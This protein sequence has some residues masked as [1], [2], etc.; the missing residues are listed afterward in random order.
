MISVAELLKDPDFVKAVVVERCTG[1][2]MVEGEYKQNDPTKLRIKASVQHPKPAELARFMAE[3]ERNVAIVKV[4]SAEK[5]QVT[6]GEGSQSDV[7]QWCGG[8]YRVFEVAP[9]A[10]NGHW[11]AFA[12]K[13]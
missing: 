1:S 4:Y 2:Y 5:L 10:D 9:W 8:R 11:V 13:T 6:G 3:G 7:V 12:Q